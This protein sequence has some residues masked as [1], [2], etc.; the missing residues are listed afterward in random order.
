MRGRIGLSAALAGLLVLATGASQAAAGEAAIGDLIG[1]SPVEV[2]TRLTGAAAQAPLTRGFEVADGGGT[3]AYF[4]LDQLVSDPRRLRQQ[5]IWRTHGDGPFDPEAPICGARLASALG[6]RVVG[7]PVL[8]FRDGRLAAVLRPAPA[9]PR[10]SAPSIEDRKAYER[11]VRQARP[12]PFAAAFGQ[13]PLEDGRGFLARWSK[14]A[15]EPGDQLSAACAPGSRP[16]T[17]GKSAGRRG[18]S[19]SDM[20]GLALLPFAV[21]LPAMNRDRE[22]AREQGAATLAGLSVGQRLPTDPKAFARG[23]YG[24][25]W[26]GS[27]R[28]DYGVLTVDLGGWK[29]RNLSDKRDAALVGIEDGVVA[30][31]SPPGGVGPGAGLLCVDGEGQAG[32]PRPGCWGWGNYR[33]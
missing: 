11:W 1:L 2:R 16:P 13:L 25:R 31:I 5:A 22:R 9:S 33:P 28:P 26:H 6:D 15:A 8:V 17:V 3:D 14:D 18:L 30:W 10:P 19:N 32:A 24:L 7:D 21:K 27:T 23:Q 4:T 20:Q 12:S 29:S